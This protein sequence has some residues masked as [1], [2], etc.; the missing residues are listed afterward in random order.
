MNNSFF[1]LTYDLTVFIFKVLY[2]I[3]LH[4][5]RDAKIRVCGKESIPLLIIHFGNFL[6]N[7]E[8]IRPTTGRLKIH[9]KVAI[10]YTSSFSIYILCLSVCLYLIN[11]KTAEPIGPKFCLGP[12]MTQCDQ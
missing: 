7:R 10:V 2:D 6:L 5:Y 1:K 12:H 11:V 4:K 3:G 8:S 9:S